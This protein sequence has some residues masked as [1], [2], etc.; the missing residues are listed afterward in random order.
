MT[1]VPL[2]APDLDQEA[3]LLTEPAEGV[4]AI[5]TTLD[6]LRRTAGALR[7]GTGP[8]AMDAERAHGFRYSQRAYLIQL[9]RV[10]TGGAQVRCGGDAR[11][12]ATLGSIRSGP[13][14]PFGPTALP[15]TDPGGGAIGATARTIVRVPIAPAAWSAGSPGW[16]A[17]RSAR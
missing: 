12:Q 7:S 11:H 6:A 8:V 2:T 1:E 3:E 15:T 4:P 9:R 17:R 10:L 14:E 13:G 16:A 5:V